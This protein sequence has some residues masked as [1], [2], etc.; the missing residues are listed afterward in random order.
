MYTPSSQCVIQEKSHH[1]YNRKKEA[2]Y[3]DKEGS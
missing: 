2:E 3:L 1:Q